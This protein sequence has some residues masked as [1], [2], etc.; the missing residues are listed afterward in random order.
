V[1]DILLNRIYFWLVE[2]RGETSLSST[3]L[4]TFYMLSGNAA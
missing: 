4:V 1:G 3:F 2:Y